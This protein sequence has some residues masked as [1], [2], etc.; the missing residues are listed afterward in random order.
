MR[1][2]DVDNI[3]DPGL[4]RLRHAAVSEAEARAGTSSFDEVD[5]ARAREYSLLSTLLARSP[6]AGMIER[7]ARLRGDTTPLGLAH[8]ALGE[9]AARTTAELAEREYFDLFVG[10]GDGGLWP[11]ASYYLT[12]FLQGRPLARLRHTLLRFGIER[13][14]EHS[15]PEDHVAFLLAIMASLIGG[16]I[17]APAGAE[18]EIFEQYLAL[19][20]GRFF[21][22]LKRAPSA[23]FYPRVGALG[24]AFM[25]IEAEAFALPE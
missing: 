19:W 14:P 3:R 9:A 8:A 10:L 16:R 5:Q 24:A 25:E 4:H 21:A 12:G 11:Y 23:A 2:A 6:D 22:D 20:I 17:A 7:L 13:T 15:E 1:G 18:R